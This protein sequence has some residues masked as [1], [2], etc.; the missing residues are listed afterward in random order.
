MLRDKLKVTYDNQLQPDTVI[1][2]NWHKAWRVSSGLNYKYNKYLTLQTGIAF[3]EKAIPES[4]F[5]PSVPASK[6]ILTTLGTTYNYSN[7]FTISIGYAHVF[8]ENEKIDLNGAFGEN[9][10]GEM[11]VDM[12]VLALDLRYKF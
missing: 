6:Q 4:T 7:D 1:P 5:D 11:R 12:N 9:L 2:K 8:F 3:D 10:K